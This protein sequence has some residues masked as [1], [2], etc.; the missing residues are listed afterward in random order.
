M[1]I[2][3]ALAQM[4]R[5]AGSEPL[6]SHWFMMDQDRIDAF[7]DVTEDRQFI[8]TDPV[9][10]AKTP[11]GGTIAHGLLTLSMLSAMYESAAKMP[12]GLTQ[13]VNYG[14]NR[15][16]F[17]SPVPAGAR[18]RGRF[19]LRSVQQD[20]THLTQT[21]DVTVEIENRERPALVA[22]WINRLYFAR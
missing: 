21:M 15:I 11:F 9:A 8:H 12:E 22:E 5:L 10:A 13:A 16:R 19:A 2:A 1:S 18:I 17:V 6:V 7:A 3:N 4:E 14:Y 20:D